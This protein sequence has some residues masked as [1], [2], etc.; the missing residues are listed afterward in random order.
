[1]THAPTPHPA[2]PTRR[3]GRWGRLFA[4]LRDTDSAIESLYAAQGISGVRSRFVLPLLRL[5]HE[6]PATV[7]ALAASLGRSH[8]AVSQTVAAMRRE[9][10]VDSAPGPDARTRVVRL[11]ARGRQIVP[12]LAAEWRAT[13]AAVAELDDETDRALSGAAERVAGALAR[14]PMA[15]RLRAHLESAEDDGA[16]PNPGESAP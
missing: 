7:S 11:S 8:S 12:V 9:G 16:G 13:E 15:E 5:A 3:P 6:G 10:L 1:M 2:D 4:V 14:R